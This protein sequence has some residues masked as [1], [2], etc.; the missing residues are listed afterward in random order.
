MCVLSLLGAKPYGFSDDIKPSPSAYDVWAQNYKEPD[1]ECIGNITNIED[2]QNFIDTVKPEI[3]IHMAAQS[4][5]LQSYEDPLET[6]RTNILGTTNLLECCRTQEQLQA[7]IIVTTDKVYKIENKKKAFDETDELGGK[8]LYSASKACCEL[9]T[10]SYR[11]S[12]F[13]NNAD[14]SSPNIATARAGNVIGGGDWAENRIIPDLI[15]AQK[16]G[17]VCTIRNP[18]ATRPWQHVLEPLSGYLLLA[19]SL[20]S[21][22]SYNGAWNFG[23]SADHVHTVKD[24]TGCVTAF[25]DSLKIH[26]EDAQDDSQMETEFLTIKSTKAQKELCWSAQLS[27]D[28]TIENTCRWYLAETDAERK[29]ITEDQITHFWKL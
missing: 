2:F 5:V 25:C 28:E 13:N 11:H 29:T 6:V 24:L 18:N 15:R 22:N 7:V 27:F 21:S 16:S 20:A 23:P 1:S 12:F 19:E 10:D 3:I 17:D 9:L 14:K 26:Y 8:D 4:L